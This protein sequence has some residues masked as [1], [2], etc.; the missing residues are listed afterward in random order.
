MQNKPRVAFVGEAMIELVPSRDGTSAQLSLA[1]DVLNSAV[2]FK[3]LCKET[4]SARFVTVVGDDPFSGKIIETS[5]H[6]DLEV[7]SIRQQA[8][9]SCGLL[10]GRVGGERLQT[11]RITVNIKQQRRRRK[12]MQISMHK[13]PKH[14]IPPAL[15]YAARTSQQRR[16]DKQHEE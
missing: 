8:G 16:N 5:K 3:R 6:E 14:R 1:G 13:A 9:A 7:G 2:Y 15:S 12:T 11:F 10:W 4:A